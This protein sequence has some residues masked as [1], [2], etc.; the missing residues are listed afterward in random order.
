M[1]MMR[2]LVLEYPDDPATYDLSNEFL[3]GHDL[4]VA[5][6]LAPGDSS[7]YVYFPQGT[8]YDAEHLKPFGGKQASVVPAS[9]EA[10]PLFVREGAILFRAP[11]MQ[12][13]REWAT[14]PLTLE[15]FAQAATS[16]SYYEDDG[17]YDGASSL[18][19][20]RYTPDTAGATL[21]LS[22][23][24]GA[25]QPQHQENVAVIHFA[26]RPNTVLCRTGNQQRP[27]APRT[28]DYAPQTMPIRIPHITS[29]LHSFL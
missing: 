20:V 18:R 17:K 1:P 16:R 19:E 28:F 11:V 27:L 15:V 3:F 9:I 24:H 2:A 13:T 10:L 22:A 21:Q 8:W 4:L 14:A 29:P 7:R 26:R 23:A 12:T 25:Y 5:R 6:V